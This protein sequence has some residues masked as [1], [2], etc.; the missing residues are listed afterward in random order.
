MRSV[1]LFC[2]FGTL[3][4]VAASARALAPVAGAGDLSDPDVNARLSASGTAA[5]SKTI[6]KVHHVSN[7]WLTTSNFGFFG[8]P[9]ETFPD[10]YES[11]DGLEGHIS[12][13]FPARGGYDYLFQGGI[14][15]G[16]IVGDDTLVSVGTDGWAFSDAS[17]ELFPGGDAADSIQVRSVRASSPH[18]SED[19]VSEEDFVAVY[20]D[21]L[22]TSDFNAVSINHRQPLNIRVK[23][24]SYAWSFSYAEDMV[25]FDYEITNI[26]LKTL[27]DVYM[28]VYLDGDVGPT[29]RNYNDG[30]GNAQD[31]FTGFRAFDASGK[32]INT[33]WLADFDGPSYRSAS[34]GDGVLVPGV[35][36]LRVVR[37]PAKQ[38]RT[39]YN[40]WFSDDDVEVDW[41][42]GRRFPDNIRGTPDGDVNKYLIMNGWQNETLPDSL[43]DPVTGIKRDPDQLVALKDGQS[44]G[45][46]DTRFLLSFGPFQVGV[47]ETLP[48]TIGYFCAENFFSGGDPGRRDF[49][50]LDIN[51]RWVQFVFDNPS[52]DTP[53]YDYGADGMAATADEGEGDGVNDTGDYFF[54]EDVGVDGV[55][56]TG[57]FG[58]AN[59]RLDTLL[60]GG[61]LKS[62]DTA[63]RWVI[64]EIERDPGAPEQSGLEYLQSIAADIDWSASPQAI[65]SEYPRLHLSNEGRFGLENGFLD[66]GDGVPDFQGPPPPAAPK[67]KVEKPDA[68]SIRLK[69]GR[70][71]EE[72]VDAFIPDRRRQHDFQ[73]YRIYMSRSGAGSD[74]TM[75]KDLDLAVVPERAEDGS[76]V[77]D[78]SG[79][80]V[81]FPDTIGRNT[82]FGAIRNT[83]ADSTEYAYSWTIQPLVSN[84]PLYVAVT[85]YDNGYPP[86]R[87]ESLE[88]SVFANAVQ[89]TPSTPVGGE[90]PELPVM[91]VPNPYKITADYS[92]SGWE[93]S[94]Q[95]NEFD[96][97][98]DFTNLKGPGTVRIFTLAGDLV[99]KLVLEEDDS[100][101]SWDLISRNG[102]AVVSGI[103]LF[104]VDYDNGHASELG[105]FVIVK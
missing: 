92:K 24:T 98:L 13:Q 17:K 85:A 78:G 16:A 59:G 25:I 91:V 69:W 10:H 18:Y 50:D 71:S 28:G 79:R 54:G 31:D 30:F 52:V 44:I 7:I 86:A 103:Y 48:I 104:T 27:R 45:A 15:I 82:G 55:P 64:R 14:W 42:P 4:L 19:A 23:E 95:W 87:L 21:T 40:W 2:S 36:A 89:V 97:R 60:V 37:T 101:I 81:V 33:A 80:A 75:L 84:W 32:V 26:G 3:L 9:E 94:Q 67:L 90:G 72:F 47:G 51:A 99:K 76:L 57:D 29:P 96:R 43:A 66:E 105:K 39:T 58:E 77:L 56:G 63:L 74:F 83:D 35:M 88:S 8:D 100:R 6:Q 102:Q 34:S 41:G 53:T 49:T 68:T 61:V 65:M 73:G 70:V 22:L 12:C 46:D 38:L 20:T 5:V 62:E 11:T 1:S 93:V